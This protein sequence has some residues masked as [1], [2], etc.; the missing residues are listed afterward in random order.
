MTESVEEWTTAGTL[1]RVVSARGAKTGGAA[2]RGHQNFYAEPC[3][4]QSSYF[5]LPWLAAK[6]SAKGL[7]VED[8]GI[9]QTE[10]Q[11]LRHLKLFRSW[12]PAKSGSPKEITDSEVWLDSRT[13]LPARIEF[14]DENTSSARASVQ[15]RIEYSDYRTVDGVLY[16]FHIK[17]YL[18]GSLRANV[19]VQDVRFNTGL[20]DSDFSSK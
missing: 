10:G 5:P 12:Q 20:T 1:N 6:A 2:V 8:L 11:G 3:A 15:I 14:K 4:S 13:G 17:Q 18:N 19:H 16:P 7:Q 9:E